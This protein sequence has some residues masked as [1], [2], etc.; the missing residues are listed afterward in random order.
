M[1]YIPGQPLSQQQPRQAVAIARLLHTLAVALAEAHRHGIIH[2]DLKPSNILIQPNGEP[3]VTDFGLALRLDGVS[4]RLTQMGSV[5]GTP[6]YMAPEQARGDVH[7]MGPACDVYS[8]GV[9]LYEMLTGQLP[10]QGP[11]M[12][13]LLFQVVFQEPVAALPTPAR[14]RSPAGGHL[15]QG[16]G[17]DD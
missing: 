12:V 6:H 13:A 16:D 7:A 4:N 1:A 15:S 11:G 5:M 9:I 2:R 10:F 8:L 17:Q 3:V 14:G